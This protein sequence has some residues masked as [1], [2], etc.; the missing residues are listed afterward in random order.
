[1]AKREFDLILYGATGF[2]GRLV[3]RHLYARYGSDGDLRWAL[4]GRNTDKLEELRKELQGRSRK[5]KL[6]LITADSSDSDAVYEMTARSK[7]VCST[8]GPYARYGSLLVEACSR[9][10][11][12]YCDLTGEVQWIARM[13]DRHQSDAEHSGARIVHSCGFDSVPSDLGNLF[14]QTAMQENFGTPATRVRGR[15]GKAS[16][17]AS[18]GTVASLLGVLEEA[19]GNATLRRQLQ[20]KYLLYPQGEPPGP[21]VRD[22]Y[23]PRYEAAFSKWTCPFVMATINE[24]VVRRSNAVMG[25]PWGREFD[26]D[27][28]QLCDNRAQA[29]AFT[30]GLGVV[31]AISGT[32]LGRSLL[33]P[34]LP[35]PGSGP[36]TQTREEGFFNLHIHAE[37]PQES[38]KC[39]RATV[40]GDRDPGYGATSKMLGEAAACLA[41]DAPQTEGGVWTPAS[42]LGF[43]FLERLEKHAGISFT[44]DE[45]F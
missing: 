27:E 3:A 26:Y 9:Q 25:F 12:D 13:I 17:G 6:S 33:K 32:R 2:T 42:A 38:S 20:N 28:A 10:G 18:G 23:T 30:A 16:G 21:E 43:P 15:L 35:K 36:D 31:A 44:L 5:T 37:H 8:V 39:L 22:Q 14:I 24:R 34:V 11:T 40:Y 41:F 45:N 29:V 4:A 19:S 7:V 1:M